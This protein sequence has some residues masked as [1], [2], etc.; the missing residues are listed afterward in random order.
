MQVGFETN[1]KGKRLDEIVTSGA[2]CWTKMALL[3]Q[4]FK[5]LE[6]TNE[7]G[8]DSRYVRSPS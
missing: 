7:K 5:M 6:L 1:I 2:S 4:P 3:I 8:K